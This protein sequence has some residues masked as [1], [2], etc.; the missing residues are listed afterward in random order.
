VPRTC[1]STHFGFLKPKTERDYF[2]IQEKFDTRNK[3]AIEFDVSNETKRRILYRMQFKIIFM[4]Q[5][6]DEMVYATRR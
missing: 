6:K 4:V 1:S 2:Y 5:V 3:D